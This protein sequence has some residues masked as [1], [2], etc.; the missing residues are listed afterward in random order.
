MLQTACVLSHDSHA[1]AALVAGVLLGS[2]KKAQ[3]IQTVAVS[4]SVV[5]ID[6]SWKSTL[7][8]SACNVK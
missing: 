1:L 3:E 4:G 8:R 6:S 5:K 2:D 7:Q